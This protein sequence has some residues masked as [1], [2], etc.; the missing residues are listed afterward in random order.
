MLSFVEVATGGTCYHTLIILQV[1]VVKV[2]D[3][4]TTENRRR[5]AST[6]MMDTLVKTGITQEINKVKEMMDSP[7]KLIS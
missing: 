3:S 1:A 7:E 2:V 5:A 4:K 6:E